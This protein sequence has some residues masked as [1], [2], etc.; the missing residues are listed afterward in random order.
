MSYDK[1]LDTS[2]LSCPQVLLKAKKV[3]ASM[4]KGE[5]LKV[6]STDPSS[7]LDFKVF[8]ATHSHMLMKVSQQKEKFIFW[9]KK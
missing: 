6:I 7:I 9:I 5:I 3:L 4:G 8:V 1:A 2:G